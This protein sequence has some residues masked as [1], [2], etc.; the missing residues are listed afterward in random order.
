MTKKEFKKTDSKGR[1]EIW[2]WEE[3]PEAKQAIRKLHKTIA[4]LELKAPDYGVGK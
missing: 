3:T 4:E 1:E 2:E